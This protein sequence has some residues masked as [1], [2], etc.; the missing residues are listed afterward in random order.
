MRARPDRSRTAARAAVRATCDL[1]TGISLTRGLGRTQGPTISG[2][3]L[4][5]LLRSRTA[6]SLTRN[7]FFTRMQHTRVARHDAGSWSRFDVARLQVKQR[8][9]PVVASAL[10]SLAQTHPY[11]AF[12]HLLPGGEGFTAR[13]SRRRGCWVGASHPSGAC[14][15][16]GPLRGLR[17]WPRRRAIGPDGYRRRRTRRRRSCGIRHRT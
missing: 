16:S 5:V 15:P 2:R 17:G 4:A 11:P 8:A 6:S 3:P 7:R 13:R 1:P 12:G 10:P 9:A 14:R